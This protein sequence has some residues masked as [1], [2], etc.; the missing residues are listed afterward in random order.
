ML[1]RCGEDD[2]D[3]VLR[4]RM[5]LD[6]CRD[7]PGVKYSIDALGDSSPSLVPGNTAE[8]QVIVRSMLVPYMGPH[9]EIDRVGVELPRGSGAPDSP[10]TAKACM[11]RDRNP[12]LGWA[13][14][15]ELTDLRSELL[16]VRGIRLGATFSRSLTGPRSR[17]AVFK[18]FLLSPLECPFLDEHPLPL[19]AS[20]RPAKPNYDRL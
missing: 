20:A 18:A 11:L 3:Q 15:I 1:E 16:D 2:A 5:P 9:G 7:S 12:L 14:R 6:V 13:S 10:G 4:R 17:L 19:I 8:H